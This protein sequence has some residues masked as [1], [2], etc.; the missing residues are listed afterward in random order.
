[1]LTKAHDSKEADQ[2]KQQREQC[3][4]AIGKQ[5]I[6]ILGQPGDLHKVDVR[7]V[8]QDRYRVNV[9]VGVDAACLRIAHS[10]FLVTDADG[11]VVT[12]TPTISKQY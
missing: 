6:Q 4:A 9:L 2:K 11:N 10:Y 12:S 8:G 1:M 5:V 3:N 7:Q